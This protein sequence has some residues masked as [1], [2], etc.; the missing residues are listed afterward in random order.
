MSMSAKL[1]ALIS[2]I[3]LTG[4]QA[5][6]ADV[7]GLSS[8]PISDLALQSESAE[9]CHVEYEGLPT[10]PTRGIGYQEAVRTLVFWK[11]YGLA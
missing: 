1:L 7:L 11:M 5:M 2:I 9:H 8:W 10:Q 4:V 6:T 3:S